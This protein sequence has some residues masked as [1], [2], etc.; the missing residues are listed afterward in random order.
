MLNWK[1]T[2]F[3]S[4]LIETENGNIA[5]NGG[6]TP[7]ELAQEYCR[8][9]IPPRNFILT[10]E[11]RERSSGVKEFAEKYHIPVHGSI[12]MFSMLRKNTG[13]VFELVNAFVP[14]C[15]MEICG[16]RITFFHVRYDS[17]DPI[18]FLLEHDGRK[19][20]FVPDGQLFETNTALLKNCD[21]LCLFAHA[22]RHTGPDALRRRRQS[23]YHTT[24]EL[25]QIF[26][27]YTGKL[28]IHEV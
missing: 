25:R 6:S 19:I 22:P 1:I 16:C 11:H 21:E 13:Q 24:E 4:I 28:V 27:G 20:G 18:G 3:N 7:D 5:V 15:D 12:V 26:A 8:N 17:I 2:R 14:T 10:S 23:V 9:G